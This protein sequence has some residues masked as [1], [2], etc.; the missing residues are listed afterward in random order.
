VLL[1][2]SLRGRNVVL[3]RRFASDHEKFECL[4]V[5]WQLGFPATIAYPEGKQRYVSDDFACLL[6]AVMAALMGKGS[7][8]SLVW[9]LCVSSHTTFILQHTTKRQGRTTTFLGAGE[10]NRKKDCIA[11]VAGSGAGY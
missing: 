6:Q 5:S 4:W 2:A 9:L 11:L 10:G 7:E 1:S 3:R 8:W